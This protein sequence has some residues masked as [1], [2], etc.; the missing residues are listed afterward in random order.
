L[1]PRQR[2]AVAVAVGA[3]VFG[4]IV[5][6]LTRGGDDEQKV[7]TGRT[8][9]S[10]TAATSTTVV[11]STSSTESTVVTT[12]TT[13]FLNTTTTALGPVVSG[14][15]AVLAKP[16][17]A[18]TRTSSSGCGSLN[19]PGWS[20]NCGIVQ[21][22][23]ADLAWILETKSVI[24]GGTA[25]RA[26]VFRRQSGS[27]WTLAL[28]AKDDD[29]TT[30]ADMRLR[31]ADVSGDGS[32]DIVFGFRVQGTGQILM[33]DVV[34]GPGEVVVHRELSKGSVRVSSGQLDD[35]SANLGPDDPSCC[36]SS[37]TH[38]EVRKV[39]GAWRLVRQTS[40]PPDDV[41]PSQL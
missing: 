22:R 40:V 33:V 2:L 38:G 28:A 13:A 9:T 6:A 4:V 7:A 19:D 3:L 17:V 26:Y 15:G 36:P 27:S 18:E 24:G 25:R 41:P 31:S 11:E 23:D 29:G 20:S 10:T 32:P 39:S 30:Y 37:Y 21:A 35:W 12:S 8:T 14:E 1:S 5:F 16:P 34:E